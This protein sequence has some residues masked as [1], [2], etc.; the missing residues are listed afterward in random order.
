MNN[1]EIV[2]LIKV[3]C[4]GGAERVITLLSNAMVQKGFDVTFIITHQKKEDAI[5]LNFNPDIKVISLPDE[6]NKL[7]AGKLIPFLISLL[8]RISG[9]IETLLLKNR[10]SKSR[11]LKY[12]ASN[13]KDIRWLKTYFKKHKKA[14]AVAF[15]YDASFYTLL[16][17]TKSN[18]V[19][20]SERG[21]PQ[22]S[23]GSKTTMA[24][25]KNLFPEA[26]DFVFQSPDVQKWYEKNTPVR[27]K[28]IFNPIKP[29]LPEP[30]IGERKK[31][32]VNFC[33]ISAEKNLIILAD[34][35][36]EFHKNFPDYELDIIGDPVGNNADGYID[37]VVEHIRKLGCEDCIHILPAIKDIHSVINDYAMF[38]SS[39]D[40]EGMSNSMLEAMAMGLP[41]VCTDCPAGGARAVIKDGE[42]GLLTPVGDS[43]ALYLAMKKVAENPGLAN[44]LSQ[45]SV[46]IR[47]EQSA[48]KITEEWMELTN[49]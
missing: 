33:R 44:K 47:E 43:H 4:G 1:K 24:L 8:A 30:Y 39:S 37:S 36:A 27:G 28:V 35:F 3:M 41:C 45:N 34:A 31:R 2:F 13:Y 23:A 32:I 9:K 10:L 46:K 19:I 21:D 25:I 38:V 11:I 18:R 16:S 6:V 42:N 40:F 17:A 22:Q 14:S 15:M 20:I 5:L 12:I 48:E 7:N 29:D 26:D 49:G